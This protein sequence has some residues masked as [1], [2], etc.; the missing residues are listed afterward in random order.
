MLSAGPLAQTYPP[1]ISCIARPLEQLLRKG[2]LLINEEVLL[3]ASEIPR[4]TDDGLSTDGYR[5]ENIL[6]VTRLP[7]S[8]TIVSPAISLRARFMTLGL[9]PVWVSSIRDAIPF[10]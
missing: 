5:Y 1:E 2:R 10:S 4:L 3:I 7:K 8:T 6:N 9:E